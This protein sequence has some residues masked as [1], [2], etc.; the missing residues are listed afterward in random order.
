MSEDYGP[1]QLDPSNREVP[2]DEGGLRAP[3]DLSFWR[4]AWWWFDFAVLVNLARFRIWDGMRGLDY[5]SSRPEVD[6]SRIGC[7]GNSGGGT[8]TA[9][10]AA[11]DP[12]VTVAAIGCYITTLRRRMGNRIQKDP[13]ADPEQDIFGFVSAGIDHAGLL[14]MIPTM[15]AI[16]AKS[17]AEAAEAGKLDVETIEA[18]A[19]QCIGEHFRLRI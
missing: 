4:K 17:P 11:L 13:D 10:I 1:R 19:D 7:V 8:L 2:P 6:T 5:L 3:A 16:N 12:R 9:Y 18:Y 14:A 15:H